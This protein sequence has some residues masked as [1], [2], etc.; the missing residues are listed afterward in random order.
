[1]AFYG[2]GL[3]QRRFVAEN[4]STPDS[5]TASTA[6][7][8][9]GSSPLLQQ[10]QS[11]P[12]PTNPFASPP[13]LPS[14]GIGAKADSPHSR[15]G[16]NPFAKPFENPPV[17]ARSTN[18]FAK[19]AM[20][21]PA[22]TQLA[23][24]GSDVVEEVDVDTSANDTLVALQLTT[25][26]DARVPGAIEKTDDTPV[27]E[28][29]A[30]VV[31]VAP[32]PTLDCAQPASPTPADAEKV[33]TRITAADVSACTAALSAWDASLTSALHRRAP[34]A[35]IALTGKVPLAASLDVWSRLAGSNKA[36][37]HGRYEGGVNLWDTVIRKSFAFVSAFTF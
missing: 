15:S 20:P 12:M 29:A 31:P 7:A 35:D 14:R 34:L 28:A 2:G 1:M 6:E 22:P 9:Q 19:T 37:T 24:S 21:P 3:R 13:P 8:A 36:A 10:T 5:T 16:K 11:G 32:S 26:D 33:K 17:S 30:S 23:E 27:F 25:P 4:K 18:P